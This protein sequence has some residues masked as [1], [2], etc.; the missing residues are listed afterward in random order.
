M[1]DFKFSALMKCVNSHNF[2][3]NTSF[4]VGGAKDLNQSEL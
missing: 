1:L 4:A 3:A 2:V